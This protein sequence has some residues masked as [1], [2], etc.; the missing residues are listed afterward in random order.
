MKFLLQVRR[1]KQIWRDICISV[2]EHLF[3]NPPRFY[4]K[5]NYCELS[6]DHDN[7]SITDTDFSKYCNL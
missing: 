4:Q 6:E 3:Y 2:L 5:D 1:I 7:V